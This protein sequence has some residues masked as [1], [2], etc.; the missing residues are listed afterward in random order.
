MTLFLHTYLRKNKIKYLTTP[1]KYGFYIGV[2]YCRL[3]QIYQFMNIVSLDEGN[4]FERP[5]WTVKWISWNCVIFNCPIKKYFRKKCYK[6]FIDL[7]PYEHILHCKVYI[8]HINPVCF[9][10]N[11]HLEKAVEQLCRVCDDL[12]HTTSNPCYRKTMTVVYLIFWVNKHDIQYFSLVINLKLK[13]EVDFFHKW[14]VLLSPECGQAVYQVMCR[15]LI[16]E[17]FALPWPIGVLDRA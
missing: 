1:Q 9:I 7:Q 5:E 4:W 10:S 6:T 13:T 15:F 11:Y 2:L 3:P 17:S 16:V 14:K 12:Y 8:W